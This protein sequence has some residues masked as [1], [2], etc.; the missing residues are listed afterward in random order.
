MASANANI[1]TPALVNSTLLTLQHGATLPFIR[2]TWFFVDPLA[3]SDTTGDGLSIETAFASLSAAYAACTTNVGDG[4][5]IVSS[6]ATTVANTTSYIKSPLAWSKNSITVYGVCAPTKFAQRARISNQVK[7]SD[8]TGV[9]VTMTAHT[10]V[11]ASGSFVTDGWAIG[12]TG[13]VSSSGTSSANNAATFTLTNVSALTLTF[14]ETFTAQT[15]AEAGTVILTS[16]MA[17]MIS[18]TGSNNAF[19]NL[20]MTHTGAQASDV[21]C[22]KVTGSRNYFE[23]IHAGAGIASAASVAVKSL[24][25]SAAQENTFVGCVFGLDTVDRGNNA[26]YDI[27][28]SGAVARN[29]FID[30]ETV[31]MSTAG[32][33]CLAVYADTTTGG[34]PTM[35]KNCVFTSWNTA[36]G[37]ANQSY[38]FGSTGAC[39][40]VWF[41]DC[42]YPGYAALS[43]DSVA[44]ISGEV[45]S[46][47]SGL[48]YT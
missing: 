6:D 19:Y 47:A 24:W 40:F 31:R 28:L 44:W 26:T 9:A 30:C 42:T 39:D 1:Y 15:A 3:G 33:A 10:I 32:T 43:N 18:V 21:N 36:G 2:G 38:M 14:S 29:R 34:R 5:C 46:Q 17:S 4:I 11:R 8:M 25:L 35:F 20:H 13:T 7:T 12:M 45:N 37:N 16:H 22:L 48:M 23:N 27:L 41:V